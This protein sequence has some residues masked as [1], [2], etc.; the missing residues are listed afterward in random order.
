M[1]LQTIITSGTP[2]NLKQAGVKINNN[3]SFL[4]SEIEAEKSNRAIATSEC[5][6]LN[7]NTKLTGVILYGATHTD[8]N[9]TVTPNFNS[10]SPNFYYSNTGTLTINNPTDI[11]SGEIQEGFIV[12]KTND[13]IWGNYFKF[14]DDPMVAA[15]YYWFNYYVILDNSIAVVLVQQ[16]EIV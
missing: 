1:A 14:A 11:Q 4:D 9:S 12:T 16:A 3:K 6:K 2:D 8:S 5:I 7:A 13:I 10:G 15:G